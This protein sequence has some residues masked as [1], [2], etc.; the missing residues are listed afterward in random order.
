MESFL[1]AFFVSLGWCLLAIWLGPRIGF[2]DDPEVDPDLKVH[3]QPAL[4]LGGV[5][6]FA[7]IHVAALLGGDL[8]TRVLVATTIVLVLGMV[9]DRV[10][11][12]PVLRLVVEVGA[13]IVVVGSPGPGAGG[14]VSYLAA[15]LLVV[16]A[17]NAVNLFDGL[18]GLAAAAAIVSAIGLAVVA[19]TVSGLAVYLAAALAGFLVFNWHPAR[20]FLGDAGAYVVGLTLAHLVISSSEGVVDLLVTAGVIGLFF[21][22]LTVTLIRRLLAGQPVFTGDRSHLYDQMRRRGLDVPQVALLAGL[23]QVGIVTVVV[24]AERWLPGWAALAALAVLGAAA[25]FLLA[26]CGFLGGTRIPDVGRG[27]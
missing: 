18:D 8:D 4:P 2:L 26:R 15:V 22:D 20:V 10:G 23:A 16:L 3:Q 5:G 17:I 13:A 7:A 24:I 1:A 14:I 25:L 12:P 27:L 9:D 21:L 19:G 11:L 6:V